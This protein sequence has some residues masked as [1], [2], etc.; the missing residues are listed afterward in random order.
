MKKKS[1]FQKLFG[2]KKKPAKKTVSQSKQKKDFPKEFPFWARLKFGKNRTTLV[3]DEDLAKNRKT[4]K[5]EDGYVHRE[6]T[7]KYHKGFEHIE[8]NPDKSKRKN[9]EEM[10]LKRPRK[11]PKYMIKPHNK[12]LDMPQSLKDRYSKNNKK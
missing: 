9:G 4:K 12:N 3:I 10:Y 1:F 7:S 11:T 5:L 6:A 8:P 2:T